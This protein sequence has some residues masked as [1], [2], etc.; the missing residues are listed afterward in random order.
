MVP[1]P[2]DDLALATA[3]RH[4]VPAVIIAALWQNPD[5]SGELALV[6]GDRL[7]LSIVGRPDPDAAP[8]GGRP[9]LSFG[10]H[11]P[12][13]VHR[14]PLTGKGIS[15]E[16]LELRLDHRP[17][18]PSLL[19]CRSSRVPAGTSPPGA[20][21]ASSTAP[22]RRMPRPTRRATS[23]STTISRP[24]ST[25][26]PRPAPSAHSPGP[27][28]TRRRG[29]RSCLAAT[30]L[31]RASVGSPYPLVSAPTTTVRPASHGS[32]ASHRMAGSSWHRRRRS[33]RAAATAKA[34]APAGSRRL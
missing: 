3:P 25:P 33:R 34:A 12:G 17:G 9:R 4:V 29:R 21:A 1:G 14:G 11:R 28:S 6:E 7:R 32:S 10:L 26:A 30:R 20:T 18:H 24:T 5:R 19:R 27:S 31:I 2:V 15:R 13:A 16:Q 8:L 23:Q 22:S